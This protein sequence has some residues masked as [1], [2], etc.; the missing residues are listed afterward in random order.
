[1]NRAFLDPHY[2]D[3]RESRFNFIKEHFG[4]DFFD[5]KSVLELGGG[6]GDLGARFIPL[7]AE[8][9]SVDARE[10]HVE[11]G[12]R[13]HPQIRFIHL[14]LEKG[15]ASLDPADI[16]L[17]TGLMYHLPDP[18]K[19]LLAV[20]QIV[21][22]VL[23]LE[24]E[25]SDSLSPYFNLS[26]QEER[27][28]FDQSFS[29]NGCRPSPAFV[30]RILSDLNLDFQRHRSSA[31]NAGIHIYDWEAKDRPEYGNGWW[32]DGLRAFWT[33]RRKQ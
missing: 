2:I 20:E 10:D 31:L 32:Q 13:L 8:V 21:K 4:P 5:G 30:E 23:I 9:T 1:M 7:G 6:N 25:V 28:T 17:D 11:L 26:V 27:R 29:G 14:D 24:S 12:R 22:D 3:W 15:C 18:L 33:C 16:V 19:H